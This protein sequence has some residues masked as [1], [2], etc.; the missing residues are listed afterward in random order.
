MSASIRT[1]EEFY[2]YALAIER[3]AATRYLQLADQMLVHHNTE[4]ARIFE[5]LARKETEHHARLLSHASEL[6]VP[7]VHPWEYHWVDS[8]SPEAAPL[9]SVHYLMGARHALEVAIA[10]EKRAQEFFDGVARSAQSPP[11]V[12]ELARRFA[13]EEAGHVHAL[14]SALA[15]TRDP[16]EGWSVDLDPPNVAGD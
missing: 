8:E 4:A 5:A 9:D 2:G 7:A 15:F 6:A 12:R 10:N 16:G 3:E 14:E 1:V 11:E 13:A